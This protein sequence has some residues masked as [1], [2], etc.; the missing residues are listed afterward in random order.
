M[1]PP[2][3]LPVSSESENSSDDEESLL[4]RIFFNSLDIESS[5]SVSILE[6]LRVDDLSASLFPFFAGALIVS[7]AVTRSCSGSRAPCTASNINVWIVA[8]SG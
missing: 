5:A 8:I 4:N 1:S 2:V 7:S 3:E 6:R